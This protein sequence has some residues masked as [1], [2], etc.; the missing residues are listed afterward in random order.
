MAAL[1][2]SVKAEAKAANKKGE[3]ADGEFSG[4]AAT[5]QGKLTKEEMTALRAKVKAEAVIANKKGTIKKGD[6]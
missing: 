1:R 2:V 6:Q 4:L 3:I 5:A